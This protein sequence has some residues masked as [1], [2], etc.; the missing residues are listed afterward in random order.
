MVAISIGAP[1]QH[2]DR[3]LGKHVAGSRRDRTDTDV[4]IIDVPA[5]GA[6][7]ITAAGEGRHGLSE[8]AG[9]QEAIH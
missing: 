1:Q 3:P 4:P 2:C 6:F 7:G 8:R 9:C 5:I